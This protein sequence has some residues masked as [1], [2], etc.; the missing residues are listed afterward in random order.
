MKIYDL[1]CFLH[2]YQKSFN[3][4]LFFKLF[5]EVFFPDLKKNHTEAYRKTITALTLHVRDSF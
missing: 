3:F 2:N 4:F 5:V 1:T